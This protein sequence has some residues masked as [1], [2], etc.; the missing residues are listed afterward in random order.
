MS[1]TAEAVAATPT[2][3]CSKAALTRRLL[4]LQLAVFLQGV[5]FWVPIEK[6]FMTEIGFDAATIGV[7]AAAY[8][9]LV[10]L[11]EVVSGVLA[12]RWSRRGVLMTAL[13]AMLVAV[14]IGGF[15]HHVITYIV[16]ALVLG[17]YFAM[18]SGTLEAIVYDTVLEETGE[19]AIYEQQIGRIR[20]IEATALVLSALVGGWIAGAASTRLTYFV[21]LPFIAVALLILTRFGEPRLHQASEHTTLR[22]HLRVT[23]GAILHRGRLVPIAAA[24][25]MSVV[26][27]Q[28]IFEFGPLWL[29][30]L[31]TS[32]VLYGPF[33]AALVST[34]GL[35]GL[36]AG[37]LNLDRLPSVAV[38]VLLMLGSALTLTISHHLVPLAVAMI[39]L[40][41]LFVVVG[42]HISRL[43]HDAIPSTIRTGVAS[44][45]SAVSWLMFLPFALAFG[46]VS[47]QSG[48]YISGWMLVG[49]AV[50]A[51]A[52][53]VWVVV[54]P[55]RS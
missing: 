41:L 33:W 45:I 51:G 46:A 44:G 54:R 13:V 55:V 32:P 43:M 53:L 20:M 6:L 2:A 18:Y 14:L 50:L 11:A 52:A 49:A 23:V 39:V 47:K 12:D 7:M 42:I 19:S 38:A 22:Q 4:P 40:A 29:I 31:S 9:G 1:V 10:P 24:S 26:I 5:G 28:A 3:G 27:L 36:L 17:I 34:L 25:I 30:A 35:G 15:S 8:A 37:R 16:A 48:V 21:T